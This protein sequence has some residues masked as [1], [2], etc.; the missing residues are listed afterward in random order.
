MNCNFFES[1]DNDTST[2]IWSKWSP[3]MATPTLFA[4]PLKKHSNDG[5][6]SLSSRHFV[7][8]RDYLLYKKNAQSES[9]SSAMK[10]KY[11]RLILPDTDESDVTAPGMIKDKFPIKICLKNKFSLLYA[12]DEEQYHAWV[13]E[14]TKVF[15]RTDF[16]SRFS[17]SKIIGSGAFANVYEATDKKSLKKYA[18]KG[19]NKHY[20][21]KDEKGK[22]A[23]WNELCILRDV[24]HNNLLRLH[25]VHETK[26]SIYLVFDIYEGGELAKVIENSS[27]LTEQDCIN[28]MIGLVRGIDYLVSKE[29]VHRDLKP[30]NIMI[31]KEKNIQPEDVVIVDFG[32]A[33]YTWDTQPLYCRCGTPGYI[34]PEVIAAK[35]S[36]TNFVV[37]KTCDVFGLGVI[38]YSLC[39]GKNPFE[40]ADLNVDQI[41]KKNLECKIDYPAAT[42]AK[43]TT[44]FKKIMKGMLHTD[45]NQRITI[46]AALQS[47]LF[48]GNSAEYDFNENMEEFS[49]NPSSRKESLNTQS[50]QTLSQQGPYNFNE[51]LSK[52]NRSIGYNSKGFLDNGEKNK[53]P[54]PNLYKQSLL[55]RMNGNPQR[56]GSKDKADLSFQNTK[57]NSET[58]SNGIDTSDC[59]SKP[60]SPLLSPKA[61]PGTKKSPFAQAQKIVPK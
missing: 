3:S 18:V 29:L 5:Q 9:V 26:N 45:P 37:S 14:M 41:I 27:S 60:Q 42:F 33:A 23:L 13:A 7:L 6:D 19:F 32:L 57:D 28:I 44:E 12:S 21:E 61:S 59:K 30:N 56:S 47:P 16:H 24:N 4:G 50:I 17:V 25:E 49:S 51:D 15:I 52:S 46:K 53:V 11:A 36:E 8:Q 31:R 20:L 2:T 58:M 10:V 34:A 43:F 38:M 48:G 55:S 35:S 22:K 1:L 39:L 40:K 54:G